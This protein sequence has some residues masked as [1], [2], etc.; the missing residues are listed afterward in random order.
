MPLDD[1]LPQVPQD[2]RD[3]K[4]PPGTN[5]IR[6]SNFKK[7]IKSKTT[8]SSCRESAQ[9]SSTAGGA[10]PRAYTPNRKRGRP[11]VGPRTR[12]CRGSPGQAVPGAHRGGPRVPRKRGAQNGQ[13]TKNILNNDRQLTRRWCTSSEERHANR[14]PVRPREL[15]ALCTDHRCSTHGVRQ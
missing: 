3:G 13:A 1:W 9:R 8:A 4:C 14:G 11:A 5:E 2:S 10:A 12:F 6:K 7:S 15:E